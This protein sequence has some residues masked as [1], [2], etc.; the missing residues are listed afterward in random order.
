MRGLYVASL[1]NCVPLLS[2][3]LCLILSIVKPPLCPVASYWH[4][5]TT[6]RQPGST[7]KTLVSPPYYWKG[8]CGCVL[9]RL[10]PSEDAEPEFPATV[11]PCQ[12]C[13]FGG[14]PSVVQ[15]ASRC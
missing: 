12:S 10:G 8:G 11:T 9:Q 4:Q 1:P 3:F 15:R 13:G 14:F 5:E 6:V 7:V 2:V